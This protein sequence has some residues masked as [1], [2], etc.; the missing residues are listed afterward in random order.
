MRLE[1]LPVMERL[2][3]GRAALRAR[4]DALAEQSA[5]LDAILDARAA[6]AP[7]PGGALRVAALVAEPLE[8]LA[9]DALRRFV[10][11]E[12][13]AAGVGAGAEWAPPYG[14]LQ[15]AMRQLRARPRELQWELTL[16]RG[17]VLQ[18]V[19]DLL[20]V[21]PAAAGGE[22]RG[23]AGAGVH[24]LAEGGAAVAFGPWRVSAT[25]GAGGAGLGAGAGAEVA[26]AVGEGAALRV[27][28]RRTGDLF[29][30]AWRGG[31]RVKLKDFLR[32]QR[33]PP[34]VRAVLARR[35][36]ASAGARLRGAAAHGR[37]RRV[38]GAAAR[39]RRAATAGGAAGRGRGGGGGACGGRDGGWRG[40]VQ[41]TRGAE[42]GGRRCGRADARGAVR[43][44][45]AG[46]GAGALHR[47]CIS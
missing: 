25:R 32:G 44:R 43:A 33:S 45:G 20:T 35:P 8:M 6:R 30:P 23:E 24:E 34:P 22:A 38:Q 7:P 1:L 11:A 3:G 12:A 13:R 5:Q 47:E 31:A 26:L 4:L 27:R 36:R 19:G 17:L 28:G 21:R 14:Q 37:A 29:E 40:R 42:L 10:A 16:G 46:L 41:G 18:R 9:V 15:R 39:A 2:A